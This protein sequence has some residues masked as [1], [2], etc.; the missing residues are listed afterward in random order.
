[1]QQRPCAQSATTVTTRLLLLHLY[2]CH[3]QFA[4]C[5]LSDS[6]SMQ[7]QHIKLI[8]SYATSSTLHS[9]EPVSQSAGG[10]SFGLE[11]ASLFLHLAITTLAGMQGALVLNLQQLSPPSFCRILSVCAIRMQNAHCLAV[12]QC[13]HIKLDFCRCHIS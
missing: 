6:V 13:Q 7:C 2:V 9:C 4:K 10:K 11:L 3:S 8:F 1:M 5:S 12:S